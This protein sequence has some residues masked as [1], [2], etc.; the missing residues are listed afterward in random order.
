MP[1]GWREALEQST[2]MHLLWKGSRMK[3]R[4]ITKSK[5][6]TWMEAVLL[7]MKG[8]VMWN[9]DAIH[10]Y[11]LKFGKLEFLSTLKERDWAK[12]KAK[13]NKLAEQEW[14]LAE[15]CT[16]EFDFALFKDLQKVAQKHDRFR[17]D[18]NPTTLEACFTRRVNPIPK[19]WIDA[20]YIDDVEKLL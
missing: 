9:D 5:K 12:S 13:F 4:Y 6:F 16:K 17:V 14:Y 3:D 8:E 1:F 19:G 7:M 15:K 20:T 2:K 18:V 11:R 10:Y